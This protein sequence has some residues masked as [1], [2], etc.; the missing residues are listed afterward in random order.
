M[1]IVKEAIVPS[2]SVPPSPVTL[3][4]LFASRLML[5]LFAVGGWLGGGTIA[6]TVT[7]PP[8]LARPRLSVAV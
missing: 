3:T 6:E 7:V 8:E 1:L 4:A 5:V 2:A